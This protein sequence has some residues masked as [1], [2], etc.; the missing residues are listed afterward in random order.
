MDFFVPSTLK[1]PM[2]FC[3][4]SHTHILPPE[5]RAKLVG[6]TKASAL[7]GSSPNALR[8]FPSREN[9]LTRRSDQ[10]K[11]KMLEPFNV[12]IITGAFRFVELKTAVFSK[13]GLRHTLTVVG[14][15]FG[16]RSPLRKDVGSSTDLGGRSVTKPIA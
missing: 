12:R 6:F 10:S 15:T 11:I 14:W 2:R 4:I 13:A 9:S 16:A 8:S 5:S 3:F 7:P 1:T